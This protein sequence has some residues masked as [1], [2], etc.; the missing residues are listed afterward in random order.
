MKISIPL[1]KLMTELGKHNNTNIMFL[2]VYVNYRRELG[3]IMLRFC[4]GCYYI[5]VVLGVFFLLLEKHVL[6]PYFC[7]SVLFYMVLKI[8]NRIAFKA[9]TYIFNI[10]NL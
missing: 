1:I 3:A 7:G 10:V 9:E 4:F 8:L 5:M 2:V 6:V